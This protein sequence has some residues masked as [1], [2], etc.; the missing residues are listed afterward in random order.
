MLIVMKTYAED[1]IM[2]Q[3]L[4]LDK[5]FRCAA[6][7]NYTEMHYENILHMLTHVFIMLI[8]IKYLSQFF[9]IFILNTTYLF[10][11]LYSPFGEK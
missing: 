2:L 11:S 6:V 8:N 5:L 7:C 9:V 10:A 4:K 3:S 1:Q